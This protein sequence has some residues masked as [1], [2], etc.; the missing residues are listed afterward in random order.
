MT[1]NRAVAVSLSV[2]LALAAL[3]LAILVTF[4]LLGNR[5]PE[6]F[7]WDALVPGSQP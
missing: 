3:L 4:D 5:Q 1:R 7:L 6:P 2:L